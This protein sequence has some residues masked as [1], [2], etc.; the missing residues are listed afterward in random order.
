MNVSN[1]VA[2]AAT[3]GGP[4]V[5]AISVIVTARNSRGLAKDQLQH[6]RREA[7]NERLFSARVAPYEELLRYMHNA[8]LRVD[9]TEPI[10][11]P[12]PDPPAPMPEAQA[13]A[14]QVRASMFGSPE[15]T[16]AAE[17]FISKVNGFFV[18]ANTYVA[19]RDQGA[20]FVDAAER[21]NDYRRQAGEVLRRVEDMIRDELAGL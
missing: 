5:A 11:G 1:S 6:E 14:V 15:V 8:M 10:L 18:Y 9:R 16:A 2:L 3:I 21:M 20:P 13:L 17:E 7:Q 19:A 12:V 4:T